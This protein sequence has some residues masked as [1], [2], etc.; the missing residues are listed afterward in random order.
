MFDILIAC[1]L[2]DLPDL[3]SLPGVASATV[4]VEC[5]SPKLTIIH[6]RDWHFIERQSFALDVQ[7]ASGEPLTDDEVDKLLAEHRETV[8]TIQKQ[9]RRLILALIKQLGVKQVFQEGLFVEQ[10]PAYRK[11]IDILRDFQKY[12]SDGD[13]PL[14]QFT[15]Y[16][17]QTDMLQIGVPGQLWIE[18]KIEGIAPVE[19]KAAYE[20]ANPIRD[21]KVVFDE[22]LNEAREDAIARNLLEAKCRTAVLLL[23][24]T[25]D[26][27]DNV[28]AGVKLIVL[29][30]KGYPGE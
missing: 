21:G 1:L 22:S 10:L 7:D 4:A 6:I 26:L 23:G 14:D 13:S 19:N 12:L 30:V 15:R 25:H 28:P 11:R 29:T 16:E 5:D 27:S 8:A 17:Y 24:G 9:Q 2:S 3:Q 20:A 18:N